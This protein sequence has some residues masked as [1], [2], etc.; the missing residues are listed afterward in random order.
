[1]TDP[2]SLYTTDFLAWSQQQ[3]AALRAA[4][5]TGSNREIDWENVAEEIE[6]LGK[7]QRSALGS[8][9]MRIVQHLAKLEHSAAAEPRNGW[10]R[11]IRLARLQAQRRLAD[12]P[13]LRAELAEL[14]EAETARGVELAIIDLEEH[15][16]IDEVGA[17]VV[18]RARYPVEQVLGDWLPDEPHG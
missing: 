15:A 14:L 12:N 11:T 7:S 13:S 6:D 4:R 10:R 8:H 2:K 5:R 18:R 3:A 16:E 17:Q 1:M 9:L